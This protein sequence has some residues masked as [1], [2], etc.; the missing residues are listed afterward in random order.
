MIYGDVACVGPSQG[1]VCPGAYGP[2]HSVNLAS[3]SR[4]CPCSVWPHFAAADTGSP[5]DAQL[6]AHVDVVTVQYTCLSVLGP[7]GSQCLDW[8]KGARHWFLIAFSVD[9]PP[10][11]YWFGRDWVTGA[12]SRACGQQE[13]AFAPFCCCTGRWTPTVLILGSPSNRKGVWMVGCS[14]DLCLTYGSMTVDSL[15][16]AQEH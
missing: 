8:A 9:S 3:R 5:R 12:G 10:W 15:G 2:Q 11:F 7:V 14:G 1:L 16:S 13:R 4:S 6:A